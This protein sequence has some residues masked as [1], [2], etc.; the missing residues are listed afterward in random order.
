IVLLI[1]GMN[2][3]VLLWW[4]GTGRWQGSGGIIGLGSGFVSVKERWCHLRLRLGVFRLGDDLTWTVFGTPRSSWPT[5]LLLNVS[6][7]TRW[8]N[9]HDGYLRGLCGGGSGSVGICRAIRRGDIALTQ[10]RRIIYKWHRPGWLVLLGNI[11]SVVWI[12]IV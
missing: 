5:F 4:C 12:V 3:E 9:L 11:G 1:L 8:P 6:I 2:I 7:R 10:Y